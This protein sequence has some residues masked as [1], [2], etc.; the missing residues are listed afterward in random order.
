MR[1]FDEKSREWNEWIWKCCEDKNDVNMSL[2]S[3]T[4]SFLE[5]DDL[6]DHGFAVLSNPR[7]STE[8]Q[9]PVDRFCRIVA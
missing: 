1:V 5:E 7:E 6:K 2:F 8:S 4:M 9:T 3:F